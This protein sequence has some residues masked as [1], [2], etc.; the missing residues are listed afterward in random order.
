M[1][2]PESKEHAEPEATSDEI[3]SWENQ[4]YWRRL[5]FSPIW[6]FTIP[7]VVIFGVLGTVLAL[8]NLF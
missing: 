8:S 4:D 3:E 6:I 2:A 7:T 1:E 5:D